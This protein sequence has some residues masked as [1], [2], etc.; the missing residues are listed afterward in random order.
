[1]VIV[2]FDPGSIGFGIGLLGLENKKITYLYSEEIQLNDRDF[3]TRMTCLWQRLQDI[4]DGFSIDGAAI[5]EGF[6]GKNVRSMN[7]VSTVRGVVL[8]SLIHR[9]IGLKAYSPRQVKLAVTGSGSAQKPQVM[10]MITTLLG[11]SQQ[12]LGRDE[13]DA[14]AVA[15]C[16][17]LFLR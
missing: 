3:H 17:A 11:L 16:H 13:S 6:L 7:M 12:R 2:G 10:R 4:Y 5:E 8:A 1:M 9:G 14:L 15:Y